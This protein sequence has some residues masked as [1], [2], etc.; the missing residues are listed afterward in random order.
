MSKAITITE[1]AIQHLQK[2]LHSKE[3]VFGVRLGVKNSGCSGLSYIL[4]FVSAPQAE[5]E[6]FESAGVKVVV[7]P[8]SL[9]YLEGTEI[10]CAREGLNQILKF[11][12]PNVKSS[13]GCGESFNVEK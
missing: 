9:G 8:K 7:D 5:D 4:D 3:N 6:I 10:D 13:C 1:G 12:N 2:I 11:N